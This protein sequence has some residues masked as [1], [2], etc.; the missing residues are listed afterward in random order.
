M[1]KDIYDNSEDIYSNLI[2]DLKDLPKINTTDNF[3]YNLMIKIQ[4]GNLEE[5]NTSG[6]FKKTWVFAPATSLAAVALVL[7]FFV[8]APSEVIENPLME[9]P[10]LREDAAS[11]E[12]AG[13]Q[14]L[15]S[16]YAGSNGRYK[17][18]LKPNDVV[19][20]EEAEFPF[21]ASQSVSLDSYIGNPNAATAKRGGLYTVGGTGSSNSEFSGFYFYG[22]AEVQ[23]ELERLRARRDSLMNIMLKN[24]M[25]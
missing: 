1:G 23:R 8:L 5:P 9:P 11:F 19:I 22:S 12:L 7:F 6:G 2:K 10:E 25:N 15:S 24:Q 17:M 3:E 18:V 21:D 4:N 20:T 13:K 16:F 14:E